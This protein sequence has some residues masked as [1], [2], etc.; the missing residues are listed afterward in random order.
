M[1]TFWV[2]VPPNVT[3]EIDDLEK[4]WTWSRKFDFIFARDLLLS[5]RNW[6]KLIDQCYK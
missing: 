3:F 5:V 6:P 1:L 4:S 2:S